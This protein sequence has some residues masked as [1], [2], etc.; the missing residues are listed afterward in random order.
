MVTRGAPEV[1]VAS[2]QAF[3]EGLVFGDRDVEGVIVP[4]GQLM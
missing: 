4:T 1:A 3:E 2:D